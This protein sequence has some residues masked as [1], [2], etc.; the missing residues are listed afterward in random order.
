VNGIHMHKSYI[1]STLQIAIQSK[2]SYNRLLDNVCFRFG[3]RRLTS[4]VT[5]S[6]DAG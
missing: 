4:G 2:D 5:G 6:W 1:C 3:E